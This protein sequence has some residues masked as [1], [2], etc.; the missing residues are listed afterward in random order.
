[1]NEFCQDKDLLAMEPILYLGAGRSAQQLITAIDGTVV[2]TTLAS[3][4]SDFHSAGVAPGMVVTL[5]SSSSAE[6]Q[7]FEIASVDSATHLTISVL[8]ADA[9]DPLIPP[10]AS[11]NFFFVRTY[12][13]QIQRVSQDLSEKLRQ[14]S[15]V[16][17]VRAADFADSNQLRLTTA[18]G[19]LA[20]IYAARAEAAVTADANWAKSEFYRNQFLRLQLLL[21]LAVDQDGDGFA[22]QTR[23]LGNVSLRR[24]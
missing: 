7:S 16:T 17:A 21:R 4:S 10:Q 24:V 5:F 9:T 6:G 20:A 8:R 23:S 14:I 11:G 12:R 3:T 19:A 15:E 2:G 18:H 13:A 1:M 22:R